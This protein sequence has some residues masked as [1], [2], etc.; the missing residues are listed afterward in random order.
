MEFPGERRQGKITKVQEI[1]TTTTTTKRQKTTKKKKK[2]E[3]PSWR[4]G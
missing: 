2:K 4:S 1:A 3:F